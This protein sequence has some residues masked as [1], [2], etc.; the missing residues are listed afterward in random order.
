MGYDFKC[1]ITYMDKGAYS[2]NVVCKK[3]TMHTNIYLNR[4]HV[5]FQYTAVAL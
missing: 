2:A 3:Y 5:P 4:L 1:K